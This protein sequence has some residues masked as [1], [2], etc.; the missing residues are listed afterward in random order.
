MFSIKR[1]GQNDR[2]SYIHGITTVII[3]YNYHVRGVLF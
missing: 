1:A 2:L 3:A